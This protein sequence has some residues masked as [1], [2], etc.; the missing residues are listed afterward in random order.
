LKATISTS[1]QLPLTERIASLYPHGIQQS[2][3]KGEVI[4]RTDIIPP[5]VFCIKQGYVKVYSVTDAGE[6]N[7]H[8][9]YGPESIFPI[10]WAIT[11]R[12]RQV[13]Y[14]SMDDVLTYRISREDF[15]AFTNTDPQDTR[16]VLAHA[17]DMA[18][19]NADRIDG[20]E[21]THGYS[22]IVYQLIALAERHGEPYGSGVRIMA[23]VKHHD[24]ASSTNCS[25]ETV[26]REMGRLEK[27]GLVEYVDR[28]IVVTDPKALQHELLRI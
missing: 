23:P 17:I 5:G 24:I 26:S 28:L 10:I 7:M 18:N 15:L 16:A 19:A 4:L 25:R 14:E 8:I 12:L 27:A 9:I 22:R 21:Y 11:G 6:E 2:Y 3:G 1:I 20:L 13:F